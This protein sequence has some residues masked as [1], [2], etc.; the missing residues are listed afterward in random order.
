VKY[1]KSVGSLLTA[2]A[3]CRREIN[4]MIAEAKAAVN[5]KKDISPEN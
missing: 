2:N 1:F 4:S 5:M 3:R